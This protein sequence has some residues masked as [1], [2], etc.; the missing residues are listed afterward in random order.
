MDLYNKTASEKL[1][2]KKVLFPWIT[3][4][5][6]IDNVGIDCY[7][8]CNGCHAKK[9]VKNML[10]YTVKKRQRRGVPMYMCV[11]TLVKQGA[12]SSQSA[13]WGIF[14]WHRCWL[15]SHYTLHRATKF[16]VL[17]RARSARCAPG[18]DKDLM[19]FPTVSCLQRYCFPLLPPALGIESQEGSTI[20]RLLRSS[21]PIFNQDCQVHP[22]TM[23]LSTLSTHLLKTF[24]IPTLKSF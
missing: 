20:F 11:S 6:A 16:P 4:F 15:S 1:G 9:V 12:G 7:I 22:K 13:S 21:S 8:P 24:S 5:C 19:L 18:E 3:C 23:S 17:E 10:V 2:K 14:A